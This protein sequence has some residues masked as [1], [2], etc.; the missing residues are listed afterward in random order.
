MK[1]EEVGFVNLK[2]DFGSDV[3]VSRR[4]N[5]VAIESECFKS[6]RYV[7]DSPDC[8]DMETSVCS[9]VWFEGISLPI[10]VR[11]SAEEILQHFDR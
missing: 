1:I 2:D 10:Y 5:I 9:R 7:D 4:A 8:K 3:F 11:G 6:K